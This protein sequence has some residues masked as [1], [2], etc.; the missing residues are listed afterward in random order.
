MHYPGAL[1]HVM[2]RGNAGQDVFADDRDRGRL[3]ELLGEGVERYGHRIHAFCLMTNHVHLAVQVG[4]VPLPRVMQNLAFRYAQWFN[5]QHRRFGHLFQGRYKAVLVDADSYLLELVRYI[6]TNPVRAALV[7]EP[8]AY[9]WSGHRTYIGRA[10]LDWLD[11]R[12]VLSQFG[13]N[14]EQARER[15]ARFIAEG[16]G[17]GRRE[18][19]HRG[20]AIRTIL[21]DDD[22]AEQATARAGRRER[23]PVVLDDVIATVCARVGFTEQALSAPGKGRAAARARAIVA[24]LV[25]EVPGLSLQETARR[26]RRDISSLSAAATRLD[27]CIDADP[28]LAQD[29]ARLRADLQ[30]P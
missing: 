23:S 28:E 19:F 30:I 27:Q 3:C 5:R 15:Y 14:A 29:V 20:G 7:S 2:L 17:E 9:A 10:R 6:H 24:W 18:E 11:T 12:W 25:R 21:G 13:A 8:G 1:Y 4:Q 16:T 22:F 26:L